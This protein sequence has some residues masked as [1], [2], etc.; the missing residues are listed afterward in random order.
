MTHNLLL[1]FA[2]IIILGVL[3]Q[4]LAWRYRLPAILILILVG[5]FIGPATGYINPEVI[6]KDLLIPFVSLGVAL[7]L[8]EGGMNLKISELNKVGST[9]RRLVTTGVIVS[10]ILISLSALTVLGLSLEISLVFGAMLVVTGPTVILP[11]LSHVRPK[12]KVGYTLKWEGMFIDPIGALLA[13]VVFESIMTGC[14][15]SA[16]EVFILSISRT[17]LISLL[18]SLIAAFLILI[19]IKK[20]WIPDFLDN[21]LTF[22]SVIAAF[23][24]SNMV[25]PESGLLTATLMGVIFANQNF[26]SVRHIIHF[27]EDLRLIIIS[28]LFIVL[29]ASLKLSDLRHIDYRCFIFLFILIFLIRPLT[30]AM[31]SDKKS[32]SLKERIF[33]GMMAPR[34]IIAAAMA[35]V[36]AMQLQAAGYAEAGKIVPF[37]FFIIIGTVVFYGVISLPLARFLGITIPEPQGLIFVGAHTWARKIALELKRQGLQVIMVDSNKENAIAAEQEGLV[38]YCGNI[39]DDKIS[40][41]MDLSGVG[42]IFALTSNEEANSLALIKYKEVFGRKGLYHLPV[43]LKKNGIVNHGGLGRI[44]FGSDMDYSRMEEVFS[45]GAE[46]ITMNH[47]EYSR[48]DNMKLMPIGV[49]DERGKLHIRTSDHEIQIKDKYRILCILNKME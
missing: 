29:A 22:A 11:L 6:F 3:S 12:G 17:V 10:W 8:F 41:E 2:I 37:T 15:Q 27:K 5:I 40:D 44:L 47:E 7:I 35:S 14:V 31:C 30:V 45:K 13:T 4:W 32:F 24:I 42:N 21:P 1:V 36:F 38:S 28:T 18:L 20:D 39:L 16:M 26:V 43:D 48:L 33:L 34:G 23:T 49:I 46:V 19:L 9:I 25:Q